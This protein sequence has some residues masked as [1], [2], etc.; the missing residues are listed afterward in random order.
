MWRALLDGY[1]YEMGWGLNWN[2]CLALGTNYTNY[3]VL[4]ISHVLY[5]DPRSVGEG[6][7]L[8][9]ILDAAISLLH[10]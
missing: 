8:I 2:D 5:R 9:A 4:Y 10:L 6:E 1:S 3:N 7:V